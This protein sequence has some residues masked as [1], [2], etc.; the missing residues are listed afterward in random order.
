MMNHVQHNELETGQSA[1]P[2]ANEIPQEDNLESA[3]PQG[4]FLYF[5]PI[6]DSICSSRL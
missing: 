4:L 6:S 1:S 2:E 5:F 3:P